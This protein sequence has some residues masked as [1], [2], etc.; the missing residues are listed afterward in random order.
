MSITSGGKRQ[1]AGRIC[2]VQN[3]SINNTY[4]TYTSNV[5]ILG[6]THRN[7]WLLRDEG[8]RNMKTNKAREISYYSVPRL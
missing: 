4:N 8:T 7:W 6:G 1:N 5:L 3:I 2:N